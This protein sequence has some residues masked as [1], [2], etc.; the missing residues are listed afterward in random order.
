MAFLFFNKTVRDTLLNFTIDYKKE[1]FNKSFNLFETLFESIL[2]LEPFDKLGI[3]NIRP[4][5]DDDSYKFIDTTKFDFTLYV[6]KYKLYQPISRWYYNQHRTYIFLKLDILFDEYFTFINKLKLIDE[7]FFIRYSEIKEKYKMM[8]DKLVF[9]LNILKATYEDQEVT[10]KIDD[11]CEKLS[12]D[13]T[14]IS[15]TFEPWS[16]MDYQL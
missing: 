10:S 1:E 5:I 11:Y 6:D 14:Y 7:N 12:I 13:L 16:S 2:N 9:K 3:E 8:N 4:N 15:T